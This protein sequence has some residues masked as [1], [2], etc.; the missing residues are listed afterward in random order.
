MTLLFCFNSHVYLYVLRTLCFIDIAATPLLCFQGGLCSP[1]E[2][3]LYR[4]LGRTLFGFGAHWVLQVFGSQG[5]EA[6][7]LGPT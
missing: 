1:E 2:R 6:E 5:L 7:G 3:W 4:D